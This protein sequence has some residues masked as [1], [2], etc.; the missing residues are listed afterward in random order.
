[1]GIL[2]H[3]RIL[4]TAPTG[5]SWCGGPRKRETAVDRIACGYPLFADQRQTY[6]QMR[7]SGHDFIVVRGR[8]LRGRRYVTC[9]RCISALNGSHHGKA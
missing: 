3:A 7:A 8:T 1:M 6:E 9:P 5:R 4:R 2:I